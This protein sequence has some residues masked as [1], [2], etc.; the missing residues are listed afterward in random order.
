MKAVTILI[1]VFLKTMT[2]F[3][4]TILNG[5]IV[6]SK[7]P[8][9]NVL[10]TNLENGNYDVSNEDGN[11]EIEI[12]N[13]CKNKLEIFHIEY[14]ERYVK[15]SAKDKLL[16]IELERAVYKSNYSIK[17]EMPVNFMEQVVKNFPKNYESKSHYVYYSYSGVAYRE[18]YLAGEI[19]GDGIIYVPDLFNGGQGLKVWWNTIRKTEFKVDY[20]PRLIS[21][22][23]RIKNKN[24]N[25]I[26]YALKNRI[27]YSIDKEFIKRFE[28]RIDSSRAF[29]NSE[30][31]VISYFLNDGN[32]INKPGGALFINANDFSVLKSISYSLIPRESLLSNV[33]IDGKYLS[34]KETLYHKVSNRYLPYY[35]YS[36]T[37]NDGFYLQT[38]RN[39]EIV[40]QYMMHKIIFKDMR[41]EKPKKKE[42][43]EFTLL[44]KYISVL[45]ME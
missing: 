21:L 31:V 38:N 7:K 15:V 37:K 42:F 16:T 34:Y 5:K 40:S 39:G 13:S 17:N 45:E 41:A 29:R 19:V 43:R 24:L 10:V 27:L 25:S 44:N 18:P 33:A 1:L 3:S 12:E 30:I 32:Y 35:I 9:C 11:F 28:Y 26:Y 4:Q 6:C 36:L 2:G 20:S 14:S 23:Y 22:E 8:V